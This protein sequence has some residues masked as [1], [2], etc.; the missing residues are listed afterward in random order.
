MSCD[1]FWSSERK[2][3]F[4]FLVPPTIDLFPNALRLIWSSLCMWKCAVSF[5]VKMSLICVVLHLPV[6]ICVLKECYGYCSLPHHWKKKWFLDLFQSLR[7]YSMSICWSMTALGN[8]LSLSYLLTGQ[9]EWLLSKIRIR[10]N[11]TW[12]IQFSQSK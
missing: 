1:I 5:L 11:N 7:W 8:F 12:L 3:V 2:N 6:L 9:V 10:K 4:F